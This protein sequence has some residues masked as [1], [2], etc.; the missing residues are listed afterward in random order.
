LVVPCFWTGQLV[1]EE[2]SF[3]E[4]LLS[5][6]KGV[7]RLSWV[8]KGFSLFPLSGLSPSHTVGFKHFSSIELVRGSSELTAANFGEKLREALESARVLVLRVATVTQVGS[9]GIRSYT[10]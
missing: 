1:Q 3:A 8:L 5:F 10:R 9:D 4:V 7:R 6:E 2:Y